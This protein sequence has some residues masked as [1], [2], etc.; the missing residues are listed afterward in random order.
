MGVFQMEVGG[1]YI[2]DGE[3]V[4]DLFWVVVGG[5]GFVLSVCG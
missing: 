2:L 1:Q 3:G 5:C 4:V